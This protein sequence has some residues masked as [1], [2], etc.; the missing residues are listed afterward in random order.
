MATRFSVNIGSGHMESNA[1]TSCREN[2][3]LE[4]KKRM[5]WGASLLLRSSCISRRISSRRASMSPARRCASSS[6]IAWYLAFTW[7]SKFCHRCPCR[8]I[9]SFW[10]FFPGGAWSLYSFACNATSLKYAWRPVYF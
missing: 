7:S 6:A 9:N 5:S 1:C 3:Q 4:S 10:S 8:C 2:L